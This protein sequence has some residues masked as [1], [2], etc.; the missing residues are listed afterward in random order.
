M[1]FFSL[2]GQL[3]VD[4]LV[5]RPGRFARAVSAIAGA[6]ALGRGL[7]R[8]PSGVPTRRSAARVHASG[9]FIQARFATREPTPEQLEVAVA[10]LDAVLAA[11]RG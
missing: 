8:A 11:E 6:L 10:A 4:R 5:E 1:L 9:H 3:L 2:A 7:R